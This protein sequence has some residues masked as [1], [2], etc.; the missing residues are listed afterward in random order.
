MYDTVQKFKDVMSCINEFLNRG[1]KQST[2]N[3]VLQQLKTAYTI[4]S[5]IL[6]L[7]CLTL[8]IFQLI[9]AL[10]QWK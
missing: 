7:P 4:L 1:Y 10:Y 6:K 2:I 9:K 8:P 5:T 3:N